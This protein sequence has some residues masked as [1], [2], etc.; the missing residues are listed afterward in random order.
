MDTIRVYAIY[1]FIDHLLHKRQA[2]RWVIGFSYLIYYVIAV[3]FYLAMFD[4]VLNITINWLLAFFISWLYIS[5]VYK[6]LLAA[7][8]ISILSIASEDCTGVAIGLLSKTS[9]GNA[10]NEVG[11]KVPGIII[12]TLLLFALVKLVKPLFRTSKEDDTTLPL[13]Y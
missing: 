3:F 4:P 2:P 6:R 10:M 11:L 13:S 7:T 5:P 8:F 1:S 9:I 12:S